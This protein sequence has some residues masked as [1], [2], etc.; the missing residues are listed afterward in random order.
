MADLELLGIEE[1]DTGV[2]LDN[3]ANRRILRDN[4]LRWRLVA[5]DPSE[6]PTGL[7]EVVDARWLDAEQSRMH[8]RFKP[9][10][11]DPSDPWSDYV[12]A[13]EYPV[14]ALGVP[15]WVYQRVER[16]EKWRGTTGKPVTAGGRGVVAKAHAGK[17]PFLPVRC[18]R[19]KRNGARCWSWCFERDRDGLCRAHLPVAAHQADKAYAMAARM[20]LLQAQPHMVDELEAMVYDPEAPHAVRLK[21]MTEMMDRG[22]IRAGMEIDITGAV[23]VGSQDPA[24]VIRDRLGKLAERLVEADRARAE[25]EGGGDVV[26]ATVVEDEEPA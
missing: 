24:L 2:C 12:P 11:E 18:A 26:E 13:T 16:W 23:D 1:V 14:D 4:N 19:I 3:F 22:G 20:K 25:I 7:I 6:G 9:L 8:E 21:A 17:E 15:Y 5:G 10:L